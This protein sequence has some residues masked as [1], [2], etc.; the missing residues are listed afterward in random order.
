MRDDPVFNAVAR[1]GIQ[2]CVVAGPAMQT[3]GL[4]CGDEVVGNVAVRVQN[5]DRRDP[6]FGNLLLPARLAQQVRGGED[7]GRV[8]V[9]V[10]ENHRLHY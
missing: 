1:E 7:G 5:A 3:H 10:L 4:T 6:N 9:L 2:F 8:I